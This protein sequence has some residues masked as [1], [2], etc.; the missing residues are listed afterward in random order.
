M[1]NGENKLS[2]VQSDAEAQAGAYY[3]GLCKGPNDERYRGDDKCIFIC[4]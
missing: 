4:G 2:E 1:V 3:I